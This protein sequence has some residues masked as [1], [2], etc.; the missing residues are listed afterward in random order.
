MDIQVGEARNLWDFAPAKIISEEAGGVFSDYNNNRTLS[1]GPGC[2]TTNGR[3][4]R[5][6]LKFLFEPSEAGS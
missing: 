2:L 6:A 5:M 4:H 1:K 3:L